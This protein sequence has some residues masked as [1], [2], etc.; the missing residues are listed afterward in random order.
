MIELQ[1]DRFEST[2]GIEALNKRKRSGCSNEKDSLFKEAYESASGKL[3]VKFT[4][5]CYVLV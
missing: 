3:K 2:G 4:A 1:L 5:F